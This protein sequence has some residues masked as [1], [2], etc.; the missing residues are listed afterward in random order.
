[1]IKITENVSLKPLNTFGLEVNARWFT[2]I[3]NLHD[4]Q[5]L[6]QHPIYQKAEKLIIGGGSNVLFRSDFDGIVIRNQLKGKEVIVETEEE[7]LVKAAGGEVWHEL[8]MW[9]IQKGYGG[10]EN[11]SLIPGCVGASPMQ[12]I[13][14]YGTELKD[15]FESL[16]AMNLN[17]GTVRR[18]DKQECK[19][20]YRES[21]FKH[22][23]KNQY[24]IISVTYKLN[25]KAVI[26]TSYGAINDE[27][28]LMGI[29]HPGM[30]EV[31]DA[32]IRIRKSK[33]PDPCVTG[34]AGSFFKNPEVKGSAYEQLKKAN[35]DLVAYELPNGNY[36]LAAGWLIEKSGL[37]GYKMGNAAVHDKQALVLI[38]T[39]DATGEEIYSLSEYVLK[40]VFAKF[41]VKLER[42]VNII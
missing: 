5:E 15:V 29:E 9:C 31:S 10:L 13:G 11:L 3:N 24:M 39:G 32:I 14:A 38:N 42:E 2:A 36:K 26:N 20:G 16:E 18:F 40:T 30:K 21:V 27:L 7:V 6:I 4:L 8:V 22:E 12:N 37:K 1:M 34:N 17:D 19:F 35:P 33:L 23:L 25:K 28:R 41:G